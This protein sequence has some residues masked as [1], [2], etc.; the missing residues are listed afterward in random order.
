MP[1]P[2]DATIK[3][4]YAADDGQPSALDVLP[5]NTA[6]DVIA[7]TEIGENLNE[8][9]DSHELRI[10]VVNLTTSETIQVVPFSQTLTPQNNTQRNDVLTVDFAA[11]PNTKATSGDVL[12]AVASYRVVAGA[13][14]DIST[15]ESPTFVV[16]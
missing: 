13:N 15:A 9:V 7:N 14:F 12:Q 2:E 3:L 10:A 6:F 11:V 1:N 4:L 16:A 8:N 5:L